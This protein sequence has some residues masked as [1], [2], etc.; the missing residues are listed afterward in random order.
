MLIVSGVRFDSDLDF[1]PFKITAPLHV[2][3]RRL[4][5]TVDPMVAQMSCVYL[6]KQR[7]ALFVCPFDVQHIVK[8]VDGVFDM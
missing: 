3:Y 7:F 4:N 8:A 1:F 6:R 2:I 5:G